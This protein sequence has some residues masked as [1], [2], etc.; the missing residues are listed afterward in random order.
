[1]TEDYITEDRVHQNMARLLSYA[2]EQ[3][4]CERCLHFKYISEPYLSQPKKD[5]PNED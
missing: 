2:A 4:N 3:C 5:E 1:M